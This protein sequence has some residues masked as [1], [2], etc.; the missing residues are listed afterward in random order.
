MKTKKR[1]MCIVN[2]IIR[3]RTV[4]VNK[5]TSVLFFIYSSV[6][7]MLL[8][9]LSDR[10]NP[11]NGLIAMVTIFN[12]MSKNSSLSSG[13]WMMANNVSIA[14]HDDRKGVFGSFE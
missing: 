11:S 10:M 5:Y 14:E 8:L 12:S 4:F 13:Q 1:A 3:L 6:A 2:D 9:T 7:E